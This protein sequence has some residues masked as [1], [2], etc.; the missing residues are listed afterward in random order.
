MQSGR[1]SATADARAVERSV[2]PAIRFVVES[3]GTPIERN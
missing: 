1:D 3:C 2:V